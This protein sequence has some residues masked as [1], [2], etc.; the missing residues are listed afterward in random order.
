MKE[1]DK[2]KSILLD[3]NKNNSKF[4]DQLR[5]FAAL[6]AQVSTLEKRACNDPEAGRKWRSLNDYM[7]QEGHQ[8]Q[9]LI[10]EHVT[11][12][13]GSLKSI[14]DQLGALASQKLEASPSSPALLNIA[15]TKR[16]RDFV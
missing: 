2:L 16:N 13:E 10:M 4:S 7:A 15:K 5:E 12:F 8:S 3:L 14:Q 9:R 1:L 11:Q 6:Q